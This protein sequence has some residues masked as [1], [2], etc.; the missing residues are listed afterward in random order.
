MT[1]VPKSERGHRPSPSS[2]RRGAPSSSK[3]V[4]RSTLGPQDRRLIRDH[5]S[6]S[7]VASFRNVTYCHSMDWSRKEDTTRPADLHGEI[8]ADDHRRW[9]E[10]DLERPS[11]RRAPAE[12]PSRTRIDRLWRSE[13]FVRV[14]S[15][16]RV[17]VSPMITW[18]SLP[19][20]L[21]ELVSGVFKAPLPVQAQCIPLSLAGHDIIGLS[22]TGS[23][24]TLAYVVP[25]LVAVMTFLAQNEFEPILGPIGVVLVPTHELAEQ[26][27]E[28]VG[29]F[30]S[31]LGI[32]AV[33][34][35]GAFSVNDQAMSLKNGFHVVIATPG[36]LSDIIDSRLMVLS[37]CNFIAM[38]EADKM[39][40]KCF[41]PQIKNILQAAPPQRRLLMFSATMPDSVVSIVEQFF[42]PN[43]VTVRVGEVGDAA[44][45][46][47]QVVYYVPKK[48]RKKMMV[49]KL[50]AM[51]TPVLVFA[52]TRESCENIANYLG[53]NGFR[54][55][56][57]HGGKSQKDRDAVVNAV[58][59][60]LID[61]VVSTDVLARGIDIEGIQNVVNYEMPTDINV[62]VHRIGRT[63][64]GGE[65]GV[66]TSF[67]IPDDTAIM[68]DL[69]KMLQRGKFSV[70]EGILNNPAS[71]SR[72]LEDQYVDIMP[73]A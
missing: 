43:Y 34:I 69:T 30:A 38:D 32:S 59:E 24:K 22:Q 3:R 49:E 60:K 71:K 51:K 58:I 20:E 45:T 54:V 72:P 28:V 29:R 31:P 73:D 7:R 61:I 15:R 6:G 5:Y 62:Y 67:V 13:H 70:P 40:D 9:E 35:T 10:R 66:A 44:E 1:F 48:E 11:S 17:N 21:S 33:A 53:Y 50:H 56:S 47:R 65:S 18:N 46:I 14:T 42:Q 52:N 41:G 55:A 4:A 23:G 19:S 64:R 25:L 26:V 39:V 63:G 27:R 12:G 68:F 37:Q 8:Y 57:I 36:R 16:K 2:S